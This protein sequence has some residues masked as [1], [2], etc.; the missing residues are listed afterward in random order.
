MQLILAPCDHVRQKDLLSKLVLVAV[1]DVVE[2]LVKSS[3][4]GV[5]VDHEEPSEEYLFDHERFGRQLT[6]LL[7]DVLKLLVPGLDWLVYHH[8]V[9]GLVLLLHNY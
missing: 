1:L 6:Y 7:K 2:H 9:R 5:E 8:R 4:W 3:G